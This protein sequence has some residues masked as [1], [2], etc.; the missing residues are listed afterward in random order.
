MNVPKFVKYLTGELKEF[1][2]WEIHLDLERLLGTRENKLIV[3]PESDDRV[4]YYSFP[5]DKLF[6]FFI[7][8]KKTCRISGNIFNNFKKYGLNYWQIV[9]LIRLYIYFV[10]H[11]WFKKD[12]IKPL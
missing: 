2:I 9:I 7:Y 4:K 6:S 8:N 12:S 10:Y 11:L 3:D 1:D 5:G